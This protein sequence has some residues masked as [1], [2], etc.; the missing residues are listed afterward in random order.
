MT[1]ELDTEFHLNWSKA[2]YFL[3]LIEV[4]EAS[5][6]KKKLAFCFLHQKHSQFSLLI[7]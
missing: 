4:R 3:I 2:K 6:V 7:N 5:N 1:R